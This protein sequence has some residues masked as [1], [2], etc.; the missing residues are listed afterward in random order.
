MKPTFPFKF[1][2][3]LLA[4][5]L[6]CCGHSHAVETASTSVSDGFSWPSFRGSTGQGIA[7]RSSLAR[8]WSEDQNITWKVSIPGKGWSSPV[9]IGNQIWL[10]TAIEHIAS[11]DEAEEAS[12]KNAEAKGKE[13]KRNEAD[14]ISLRAICI[15]VDSGE[16]LHDFEVFKVE[17]PGP[18]HLLN[19]YASPTPVLEAGRLYCHFGTFGTACLDTAT[20][21]KIWQQRF[22][23]EHAV[24]PGSSPVL[25]NDLLVL[26]CDGMEAQYVMALNKNSGDIEWKTDR[27]PMEGTDGDFHKAFSTALPIDADGASQILVP[28]AQ[29]F[30]SYEARTGKMLWHVNHG[31]GFSNVAAPV[32]SDGVAYMITGFTKPELWAIPVSSRGKLDASNILWEQKKQIPKKSSPLLVGRAIYLISD[33]GVLSCIDADS[34]E[35]NWIKRLGGNY[36]ASPILADGLMYFCSHE[37]TTTVVRANPKKFEQVAKNQLDGQLMASPIAVGDALFVRSDSSLYRI[38][39]ALNIK[40]NLR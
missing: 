3:T 13:K 33:N 1:F 23:S 24:G 9:A 16:R 27:P 21:K 7:G 35:L 17:E 19:S 39:S 37:G 11:E 25:W 22:P 26:V 6:V 10:T 2:A 12:N 32:Y 18:I 36:S 5:H 38:E 14:S 20:G 8:S 34:G 31:R 15:S 40:S 28:A 30:T 29:W 4:M